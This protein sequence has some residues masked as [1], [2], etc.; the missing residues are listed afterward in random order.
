ME[1]P[2]PLIRLIDLYNPCKVKV[3]GKAVIGT[4]SWFLAEIN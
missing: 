4:G 1:M 2:I 3:I